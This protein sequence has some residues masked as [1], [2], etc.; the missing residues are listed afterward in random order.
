MENL[1]REKREKKNKN[2]NKNKNKTDDKKDPKNTDH[3]R[4]RAFSFGD[5][6]T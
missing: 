1:G 5:A 3:T 4:H 6:K 2:K